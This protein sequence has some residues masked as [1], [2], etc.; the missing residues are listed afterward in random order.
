MKIDFVLESLANKNNIIII[1]IV[2][3]HCLFLR[4]NFNYL[5]DTYPIFFLELI[6][7][8]ITITSV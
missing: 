5:K 7:V 4:V 1:K 3:A 2:I 8:G 6:Y